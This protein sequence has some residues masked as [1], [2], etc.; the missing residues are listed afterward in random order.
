MIEPRSR[1]SWLK[2]ATS[3][4]RSLRTPTSLEGRSPL[5]IDCDHTMKVGAIAPQ[6]PKFSNKKVIA[7]C[8]H[9]DHG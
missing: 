2:T 3:P 5:E 7:P 4:T 8:L 1:G 6:P 9:R